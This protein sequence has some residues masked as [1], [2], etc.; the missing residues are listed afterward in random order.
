M[1]RAIEWTD[2]G[3][4]SLPE[5]RLNRFEVEETVRLGHR[6]RLPNRGRADWLIRAR[7]P[8]NRGILYVVYTWPIDDDASRARIVTAWVS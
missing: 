3:E 2:H 8:E 7:L 4:G 1:I 5:W 6:R